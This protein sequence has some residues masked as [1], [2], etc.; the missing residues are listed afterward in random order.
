MFLHVNANNYMSQFVLLLWSSA[1]CAVGPVCF[2][3]P[4][5]RPP[6]RVGGGAGSPG[7][8]QVRFLTAC[9]G[10]NGLRQLD[11]PSSPLRASQSDPSAAGG[12]DLRPTGAPP[13]VCSQTEG[14]RTRRRSEHLWGRRSC[15]SSVHRGEEETLLLLF[16]C[17]G[18]STSRIKVGK[19]K[20][21]EVKFL[22]YF[23]ASLLSGRCVYALVGFRLKKKKKKKKDVFGEKMYVLVAK[24]HSL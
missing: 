20:H 2:R 18:N 4:V 22:P 6:A 13:P 15:S 14:R 9:C 8:T 7:G 11:L 3:T 12:F 24:K 17:G 5:V 10:G 16:M 23:S 21:R 19:L 1:L